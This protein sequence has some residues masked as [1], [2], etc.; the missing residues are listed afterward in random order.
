MNGTTYE[1]GAQ[2]GHRISYTAAALCV[3]LTTG[4]QL[5]GP[6]GAQR[7]RASSAETA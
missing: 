6:E 3:R 1:K 5:R 2:I 7:L 4:V